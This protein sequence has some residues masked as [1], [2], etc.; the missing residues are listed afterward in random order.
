[1]LLSYLSVSFPEW[2]TA[3]WQ[4]EIA[5]PLPA[6]EAIRYCLTWKGPEW[7]ATREC[8]AILYPLIW[9]AYGPDDTARLLPLSAGPVGGTDLLAAARLFPFDDLTGCAAGQAAYHGI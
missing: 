3:F 9:L 6:I 7:I 5:D 1:M 4:G 8:K 2:L